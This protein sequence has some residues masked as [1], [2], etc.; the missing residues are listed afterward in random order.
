MVRYVPTLTACVMTPLP[1]QEF[2]WKIIPG[3][4]HAYNTS[5]SLKPNSQLNGLYV[6]I[7]NTKSYLH[8]Y[9]P[10]PLGMKM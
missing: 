4:I 2:P 5:H 3:R 6:G 10:I 1:W 9:T 7:T 8:M